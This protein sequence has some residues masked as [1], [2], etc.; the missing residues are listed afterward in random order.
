MNDFISTIKI[1]NRMCKQ[2]DSHCNLYECPI[3]ALINEW[4]R[5][6]KE[7]WEKDCIFFALEEPEAFSNC[8]TNWSRENPVPIYPTT[9]QFIQYLCARAFP[10]PHLR[11]IWNNPLPKEIADYFGIEPINKDRFNN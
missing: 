3:A 6:N 10:Y 11:A 7:V 8:V 4:E 2:Y 9:G 1:F 5:E